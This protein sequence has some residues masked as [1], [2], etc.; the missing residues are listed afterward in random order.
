LFLPRKSRD[1][2]QEILF[3]CVLLPTS[4]FLSQSG[5]ACDLWIQKKKNHN[6]SQTAPFLQYHYP[7]SMMQLMCSVLGL[8]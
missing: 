8:I 1:H 5:V 7:N 2:I 6:L 3:C 4:I